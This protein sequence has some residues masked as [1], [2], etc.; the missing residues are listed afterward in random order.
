M[1]LCDTHADTLFRMAEAH[2]EPYDLSLERLKKGGV[3]LQ[4]LALFVGLNIN[5]PAIK[6][7][8][9]RMLS[10]VQRLESQGWIKTDDPL[11]LK[12]GET[13]FML[14][15]EGS[16]VFGDDIEEIANYRRLGVRMAGVTWNHAN[17]LAT[18][19]AINQSDGLTAQGLK[20]VRE[21]Q[22]QHIAVDV[23]H[24]NIPGFYDILNRTDAPP[25]ASHSCCHTLCEHPRNLKDEQLKDL[26]AHGGF[27]GVNFSPAFLAPDNAPCTI[28]TVIDHIDHMHQMGGEG[29]VGYGS[30]FDGISSKPE[31]LDNPADFP[32]LIE[33]LRRRGYSEDSIKAIAGENF[34]NY[35]KRI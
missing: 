9:E 35:F 32:N 16:E 20:F 12:D 24:L 11:T 8:V 18:P 21:M 7:H 19:A 17:K 5:P 4:V 13:K 25:L 28:D 2:E 33:G 31:G 1:I 10:A 23:S 6:A 27:V 3:S 15:V 29:K 26:F 22:R 30:D 34:I 14:S